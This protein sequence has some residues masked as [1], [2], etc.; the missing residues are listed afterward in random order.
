[1]KCPFCGN[2]EDKVIDSRSIKEDTVIRRRRECIS[3]TRRFTSY[4][5]IEKTMLIVLKKNGERQPFDTN[6]LK[7][8]IFSSCI[9]RNIS[10]D[11]IEDI[12]KT[13]EQRIL[14]S[15]KKE[16]ESKFI[17]IQVMKI[18]KQ[19][20]HVAYIRFVSVYKDFNSIEDFITQVEKLEKEN[21]K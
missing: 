19:I 10:S 11:Q 13:V 1:M 2:S 6:K 4:E 17:G 9:K 20:D 18:L 14:D 8:G 16:I 12:I 7:K 15:D 3:C 21:S 5:E